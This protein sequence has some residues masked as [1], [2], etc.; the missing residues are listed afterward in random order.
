MTRSV[1]SAAAKPYAARSQTFREGG[2]LDPVE[3]ENVL[4]VVV[5]HVRWHGQ[6][7]YSRL[8][9]RGVIPCGEDTP[10]SDVAVKCPQLRTSEDCL[11]LAHPCTE[12][13]DSFVEVA[14]ADFRL[15]A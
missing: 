12:V 3:K 7:R 13:A 5:V 14:C 2:S 10:T 4:V 8:G 9:E 15:I 11:E 1:V 6:R